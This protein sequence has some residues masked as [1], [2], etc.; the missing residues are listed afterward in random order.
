MLYTYR[1]TGETLIL[2][3]KKFGTIVTGNGTAE[4]ALTGN[5]ILLEEGNEFRIAISR[6]T[7]NGAFVACLVANQS[8]SRELMEF[9]ARKDGQEYSASGIT[10]LVE[11]VDAAKGTATVRIITDKPIVLK[12][13]GELRVMLE[14][15]ERAGN[16]SHAIIGIMEEW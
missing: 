3:G 13:N 9:M 11:S 14:R 2:Q 5:S 16:E 4:I 15:I 8:E 10:I 12:S 7:P 1:K 6:C